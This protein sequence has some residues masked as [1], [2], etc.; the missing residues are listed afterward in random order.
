MCHGDHIGAGILAAIIAD[1]AFK[2]KRYQLKTDV[3][4]TYIMYS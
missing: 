4:L 2:Q 3:E 1:V